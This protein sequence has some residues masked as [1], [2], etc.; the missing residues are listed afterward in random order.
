MIKRFADIVISLIGL[1]L[2][3]PIFLFLF[4]LIRFTLGSPV[5]FQ[6]NRP[7][8]SAKKFKMIKFRTMAEAN[9][10]FGS[11]LPDSERLTKVGKFLRSSSLDE[12]PELV[13]VL[14]GDMSIVGPRPLLMEYLPLYSKAQRRRH[15]VRPGITGLAQING[16][17]L[18]TWDQKFSFDLWYV[19]NHTFFLDMQ[20][21]VKT[22][23]KVFARKGVSAS[24]EATMT[25]FTGN[26][27]L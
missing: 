20:I 7:G 15:D 21:I 6:Q 13:N 3:S 8:M 23:Y 9:D 10:E 18:I 4:L 16:R 14:K 12:L 24:G 1:I 19:D 26:S 11:P 17:N 25:K 22:V 2:L 5:F 27:E